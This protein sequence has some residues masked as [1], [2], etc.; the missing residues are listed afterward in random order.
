MKV[1]SVIEPWATLIKEKQKFIET[2][3]WKT[4]YRGELYIHASSKKIKTNDSHINE[5]LKLIPNIPMGYG[6]IIC[7][8]K[9][10]D[11]IYMD[12]EFINRIKENKREYLCGE[13]SLG[14]YAWILEDIEPLTSPVYVKG[15]LNIWNYEPN[16]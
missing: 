14:R 9:L 12:Q 5:L 16:E 13:Y 7:K 10:V 6:N 11:C 1:L 3:S 15:H 4:S 8:C 2:R